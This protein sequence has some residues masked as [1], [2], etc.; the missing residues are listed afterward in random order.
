MN[1]YFQEAKSCPR[2]KSSAVG[3]QIKGKERR[4][5]CCECELEGPPEYWDKFKKGY[6]K[7]AIQRWNGMAKGW[8]CVPHKEPKE[9]NQKILKKSLTTI[10]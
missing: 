4:I 7:R 1:N 6:F 5:I 2:C 9:S 10:S 3:F 8:L